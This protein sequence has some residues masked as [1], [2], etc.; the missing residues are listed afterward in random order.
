MIQKSH[1]RR[2]SRQ[3]SNPQRYR[4][5]MF[6]AAL[7][8]IVKTWKQRKRPSTDERIK[9]WCVCAYML[10]IHLCVCVCV[11]V[12]V[13]T[14]NGI[15]FSHSKEWNNAVCRNMD[16][17]RDDHTNWSQKEKDSVWYHLYVESKIWYKWIHLQIENRFVVTK[18][19][20]GRDKS[21][22][23]VRSSCF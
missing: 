14:H 5:T 3:N 7:F 10:F 19:S 22:E 13:Y 18:S 17:S 21:R 4:H 11:C 1:S 2:I 12:C 23:S 16:G 9:M 6:T 8:T 20:R 15:Q